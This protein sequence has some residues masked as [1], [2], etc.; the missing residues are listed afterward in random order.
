[1][2]VSDELIVSGGGSTAVAT[3]ELFAQARELAVL[4]NDLTFCATRVAAIDRWTTASQLRI[5]DAPISALVAERHLDDAVFAIRGA[6]LAARRLS[7]SLELSA[8]VYGQL[9]DR[10]QYASQ[11][12]AADLG[13]GLGFIL[14]GVALLFAPRLLIGGS[15]LAIGAA[16]APEASKRE[17]A[18]WLA[19]NNALLNDPTV[20][21]LVRLAVMSAD[22]F[23]GGLLRIQPGLMRLLGDQGLGVLGLATSAGTLLGVGNKFGVLAETPVTARMVRT[24]GS[25]AP[26]TSFEER[27][28]RIP[29][30]DAQVRIDRYS[31]PGKPDRFEIYLGGTKDMSLLAAEDAWDMT[32]NVNAMALGDAGSYRAVEQAMQQAGVDSASPV[33]FTGYS[34]GGLVAALLASS[35][36]YNTQGVFTVGG[37]VGQIAVPGDIPYLAIEHAEDI[38]PASGGLWKS[39]DAVVVRRAIFEGETLPNDVYFPAH[40]L[41]RYSETAALVDKSDDG[42]SG[43]VLASLNDFVAGTSAVQTTLYR[44]ERVSGSASPG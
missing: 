23:G 40:E 25:K 30:G 37:P 14:P 5:A 32:S 19:E 39:N 6:G 4:D 27:T 7:A 28:K 11:S 17:F 18:K 16:L 38:V 24:T 12:L 8:E 13:Y 35:G 10:L 21:Q 42:K 15:A 33:Q 2:T 1:M 36:D 31:D 22:D 44:A 9:E 43:R 26:P 20:V 3:A 34:Q 29:Q 41:G